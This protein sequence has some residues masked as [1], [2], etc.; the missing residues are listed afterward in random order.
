MDK[1]MLAHDINMANLKNTTCLRQKDIEAIVKVGFDYAEAMI[2]EEEKRKDK[3]RPLVFEKLDNV[4]VDKL[5]NVDWVDDLEF[6]VDWSQA[7]EGFDWW[8]KD[9]GGFC[10]WHRLKPELLDEEFFAEK[11]NDDS[12]LTFKSAPSFNYK[13]YWKESLR[14]R[15]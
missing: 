2:A 6:Q 14:E 4:V 11:E 3:S 1:L 12:S 13:G 5:D 9:A 15:P 10:A 7:P 8:A